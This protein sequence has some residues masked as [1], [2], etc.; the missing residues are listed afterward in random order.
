MI[1]RVVAMGAAAVLGAMPASAFEGAKPFIL[2]N[3]T[4]SA[5]GF[6]FIRRFQ[7]GAW[8]P[9]V[10]SPGPDGRIVVPFDDEDCA[11]DIQANFTVKDTVIWSGVNLC[12]VEAVTLRRDGSGAAWVDYN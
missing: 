6:V 7:T 1:A 4:Q 11:F 3:G 12:E 5:M 9:L 8:Q 2:V 10:V